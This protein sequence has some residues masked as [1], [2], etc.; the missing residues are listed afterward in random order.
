MSDPPHAS[1]SPGSAA[2]G[3][4]P[5]WL[6]VEPTASGRWVVRYEHREQPLSVHLTA[7][8]AQRYAQRRARTEGIARVLLH[9]SYTRVHEVPPSA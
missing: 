3:A 4:F 7:S 5:P 9:D 8:H 1:A 2:P 6:H